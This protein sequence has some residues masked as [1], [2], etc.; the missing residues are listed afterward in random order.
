MNH[1]IMNAPFKFTLTLSSCLEHIETAI[2]FR[3]EE[4]GGP[5]VCL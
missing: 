1:P 5:H 3:D 2:F 4:S